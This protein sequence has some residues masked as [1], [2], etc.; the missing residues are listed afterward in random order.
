LNFFKPAVGFQSL[1]IFGAFTVFNLTGSPNPFKK[2]VFLVQASPR[3]S[4]SG[5]TDEKKLEILVDG[6]T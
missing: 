4:E 1:G 3:L 2:R 5:G 6:K